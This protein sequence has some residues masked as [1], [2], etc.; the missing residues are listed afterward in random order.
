MRRFILIDPCLCDL[1]SHPYRYCRDLLDAAER[2]G[3]ACEAVVHRGFRADPGSWPATHRLD[4]VLSSVG[5]SKYTAFGELDRLSPN[6]RSR[7]RIAAPWAGLH[8]RRRRRERVETFAREIAG[9]VG[10]TRPGDIVL[11]ATASELDLAGLARAIRETAAPRGVSWHVQFHYPLYRG[12]LDDFRRQDRRLDR[13]RH[14]MR[15][16]IEEAGDHTIHLHVTTGELATQHLRLGVG[17][18]GVLP[19]PVR[20]TVIASAL[21]KRS[22]GDGRLRVACLGDARPEKQS[23]LLADVAE[24][25]ATDPLLATRTPR[26]PRRDPACRRSSRRR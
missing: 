7:P 24:R 8:T 12:F 22:R 4:P 16:A 9:V 19:Y 3:F 23:H 6:G 25:V 26:T 14:L 21:S 1:G 11:I 5:H 10:G 15:A 20:S 2:E 13:I 17:A 18:V